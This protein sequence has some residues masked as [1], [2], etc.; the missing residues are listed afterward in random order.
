MILYSSVSFLKHIQFSYKKKHKHLVLCAG[1]MCS[2]THKSPNNLNWNLCLL[3]VEKKNGG[4][5]L[6]LVYLVEISCGD[7]MH[8]QTKHYIEKFKATFFSY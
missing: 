2:R 1:V 3:I 8:A 4:A 7:D 6:M 5:N